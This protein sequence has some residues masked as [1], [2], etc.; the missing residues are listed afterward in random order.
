MR[1]IE[2]LKRWIRRWG[3]SFALVGLAILSMGAANAPF[4]TNPFAGSREGQGFA[5]TVVD[6]DIDNAFE[7]VNEDSG[8]NYTYTPMAADT[9]LRIR[10]FGS[11]GDTALVHVTGIRPKRGGAGGTMKDTLS[12]YHKTYKVNGGDSVSTDSVLHMFEQAWV[13]SGK[14]A[15][16]IVWSKGQSKSSAPL[17][18]I[19]LRRI[20]SP[21]AHLLFGSHDSPV[22]NQ[23]TY[24]V[25]SVDT[26]TFELRQYPNIENALQY[27]NDYVVRDFCKL[28]GAGS[29]LREA[30]HV[31]PGGLEFPER[32]YLAVMAKGS[33]NN[34]VGWVTMVGQRRSRR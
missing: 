12:S 29:G 11:S 21:I 25:A 18:K 17:A 14:A 27:A 15:L 1:A 16:I 30:T 13:D 19:P 9:T 4:G 31:F 3:V 10:Y 26:V 2:M 33:A 20:A 32:C 8:A 24:G 23:I 22:L 6:T 7:I 34:E 28:G 5:F